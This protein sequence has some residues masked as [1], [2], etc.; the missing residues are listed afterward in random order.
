[1]DVGCRP[2]MAVSLKGILEAYQFVS[3][4]GMS[5]H[6]AFLCRQSGKVYWHSESLDD[7]EELPADIGDEEKFLPIPDKRELD[8]GKPLVLD[9]ARQFLP[10]D[11]DDVRQI[12]RKRGA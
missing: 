1:M 11:F 7:L 8:L 6:Q 5:E 10:K 3:V 2:P 12:F 9:F 4:G